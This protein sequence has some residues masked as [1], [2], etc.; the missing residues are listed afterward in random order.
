M[1]SGAA[2]A[3]LVAIVVVFI[4][5]RVLIVPSFLLLYTLLGRR[6]P[7]WVRYG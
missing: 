4:F 6:E 3:V 1:E 7:R 5:A 2:H